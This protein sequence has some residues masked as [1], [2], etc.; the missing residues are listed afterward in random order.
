MLNGEVGAE[1]A[2][3]VEE[4]DLKEAAVY[5]QAKAYRIAKEALDRQRAVLVKAIEDIWTAQEYLLEGDLMY[6]AEQACPEGHTRHTKEVT[7][8]E[9]DS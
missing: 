9:S 1:L 3:A 7:P 2:V 5:Q 6:L 4:Y 8:D